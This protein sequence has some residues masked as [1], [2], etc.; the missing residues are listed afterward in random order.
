M[1]VAESASLYCDCCIFIFIN[2][3]TMRKLL[4]LPIALFSLLFAQAQNCPS[5]VTVVGPSE[6]M[7]GDTLVFT[8]AVRDYNYS[9]KL[10]YNWSISAGTIISGQ[11]TAMIRVNT[12]KLDGQT[13]TATLELK[14]LPPKCQ[15]VASTSAE[16]IPAAQLAVSGTFT[17][18][19]ELKNAVQRFIA[20][21][22]FKDSTV[23]GTAFIYLYKGPTTSESALKIFKDA[24]IGAF[25]YNKILPSQYKI[26]DGG[27][28]K[29]AFYEMYLLLPGGREPKPINQ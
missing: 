27:N 26:A 7:A 29:L 1:L 10:M 4:S 3:T 19:Q 21:T 5:S 17:N 2:T 25:E 18:G 24:I 13:V 22:S 16:I 11:G 23:I 8:V 9:G 28:R 20:A 12:S 15:S 6:L 14:G